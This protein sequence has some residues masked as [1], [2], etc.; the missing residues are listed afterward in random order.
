[1]TELIRIHICWYMSRRFNCLIKRPKK[2]GEFETKYL[3]RVV[4]LWNPSC[5]SVTLTHI[6]V[7]SVW[8]TFLEVIV[9]WGAWSEVSLRPQSTRRP[10]DSWKSEIVFKGICFC[11]QNVSDQKIDCIQYTTVYTTLG[12]LT[13]CLIH[14]HNDFGQNW[15]PYPFPYFYLRQG[16]YVFGSVGLFF[17]LSPRLLK[18]LWTDFDKIAGEVRWGDKEQVIR[19]WWRSGRY[20]WN[21]SFSSCTRNRTTWRRSA[22]SEC[23]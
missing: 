10:R 23:F 12:L 11:C 22:L 20:R 19:F 9:S 15:D 13:I 4:N 17:C 1:M 6:L 5:V 18:K 14:D 7:F 21:A 16:G 3:F 8:N 2:E